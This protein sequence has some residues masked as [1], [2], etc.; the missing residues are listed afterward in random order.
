[1][2][3]FLFTITIVSTILLTSCG[4]KSVFPGYAEADNGT[5]FKLHVEGN[6]KVTADTGGVMFLKI[7]LLFHNYITNTDSI[8]QN[9]NEDAKTMSL[10][11]PVRKCAF[12]GDFL[13]MFMH[14][15]TGD[16][17]TFF[18]RLDSL[19]AN[20]DG[21]FSFPPRFDTM[22]YLGFTVK[23]DSIYSRSKAQELRK[24]AEAEQAK[25]QEMEMKMMAVM[26]PI[27]EK[28]KAA[29]PGLKKKD[30]T[31]LKPFLATYKITVKPDENGVYYQETVAGTG[32]AIMPGMIVS[33]RYVGKYLDGTMFDTNTLIEGQE[34]MTFQVGDGRLISGFTNSVAKMKNGGKSTFILPPKMGYNDSLTR[35]FDVEVVDVKQ[36]GQPQGPGQGGQ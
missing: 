16:S 1:M 22:K 2:K 6:G 4:G 32:S 7:N 23:V 26:Q 14:L 33:V 35:V 15:H 28:A 18:V 25:Q 8:L 13:D 19:K 21:M 36:G 3:N 10:P 20:Y 24:V 11:F 12:K 5:C 29:E 31:L 34:P 17:A 27:Q 9:I 30:G